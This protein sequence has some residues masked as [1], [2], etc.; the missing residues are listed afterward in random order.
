MD[1]EGLAPDSLVAGRYRIVR[2]LGAGGM[3]AVYEAVQIALNRRVALKVLLPA[4]AQNPEAVARFHREAQTAAS[5]GHPNI[6]AVTDFGTDHGQVFLVMELLSGESLARV[7]ERERALA[8]GR[9]A[10]IAT[11]AL[12]ALSVAHRAGIVHRDMKPDNVYLTEVSGVRDVVKLLD[13]GV[14]RFTD[15]LSDSVRLTSTGAVLGTPS[16]MSPEQARGRSVDARTDVYAVGAML[17]EMLTGQLPFR[18]TNF[19][20]LLFAILEDTPPPIRMLRPEVSPE[21]AAIVERAMAKSIDTR[22]Q[23]ADELRAA[24][25]PF[26]DRGHPASVAPSMAY[27][28]TQAISISHGAPSS[29]TAP[30]TPPAPSHVTPSPYAISGPAAAMPHGWASVPSSA[31]PASAPAPSAIV[32]PIVPRRGSSW[33]LWLGPLVFV[34]VVATVVTAVL[35][36]SATRSA[37]TPTQDNAL[38]RSIVAAIDAA[39]GAGILPPIGEADAGWCQASIDEKCDGGGVPLE[40]EA[41]RR[42]ARSSDP[43][44]AR[45]RRGLS[46]REAPT[47]APSSQTAIAAEPRAPEPQ[48]LLPARPVRSAVNGGILPTTNITGVNEALGPAVLERVSRCASAVRLARGEDAY[49]HWAMTVEVTLDPSNGRVREVQPVGDTFDHRPQL[50][51]CLRGALIGATAVTHD[52]PPPELRLSFRNLYLR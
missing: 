5:L 40:V 50:L 25:E 41:P 30:L 33:V 47:Q 6:I 36:G 11:Q 1:S 2:K 48:G 45:T 27:A 24:L 13:F 20:A 43:R 4:F 38:A 39:V 16:Y 26:V 8:P 19:N 22:F 52:R 34:S 28:A 23:S 44:Q 12:S 49:D 9:A 7:I 21:L 32:T 31:P 37:A 35:R 14:A 15:P 18:A 46:S 42:E 3:G 10:W 29:A 17:Y 51:Q